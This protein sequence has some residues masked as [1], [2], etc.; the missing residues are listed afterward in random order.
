VTL[1]FAILI[2]VFAKT[3]AEISRCGNKCEVQVVE[4]GTGRVLSGIQLRIGEEVLKS[5]EN[6]FLMCTDQ[7]QDT[8]AVVLLNPAWRLRKTVLD[9][10]ANTERI[11]WL[12]RGATEA[13]G[14]YHKTGF[15]AQRLGKQSISE[16]PGSLQDPLRAVQNLAGV[17]RAPMNSG[18][19]L[20]RGMEPRDTRVFWA[21]LPLTQLMHLGGFASVFHPET[22]DSIRFQPT[23]W[24]DRV[25]GLGGQVEIQSA[26]KSD[27]RRAVLGADLI[28][29]SGY[30]TQPLGQ[31]WSGSASLRNSWLRGAMRLAQGEPAS[32]I[33]PRFRD[34]S[35]GVQGAKTSALYMGFEDEI[36][37]PTAD[38]EQ[39]LQIEQS[40][41]Q[42]LGQHTW[43][44]GSERLLLSGQL[45]TQ[46]QSLFQEGIRMRA[47][48]SQQARSHLEWSRNSAGLRIELGADVGLGNQAVR[49][50][51][52]QIQRQWAST[53]GFG[54]VEIGR[55]R[56]LGLGVRNTHL[57]VENQ[58]SRFGLDPAARFKWPV[59]R[60]QG[61]PVFLQGQLSRR[62]QAPDLALLV[63]DPEG[64][65]Q[66]LERA[67]ELSGGVL[68]DGR[69]SQENP[70]RLSVEGFSKVLRHLAMREADGTLGQFSGVA[71]GIEA[72]GQWQ[73]EDLTLGLSAGFSTSTR[74]EDSD[75]DV[76]P[77]ALDP[78]IQLVAVAIWKG[79]SDWTF[80]ARFRYASGVPFQ[81]DRPTAYD[82]FAQ[83]EVLLKPTV[84]EV[85]GR[86]PD[87]H[88]LDFKISKRRT[89]KRWRLQAYL[90]LQNLYNRRVPEPVL[91]GFE[92]QPVFGFGM[93]FL[94]VFGVEAWVWR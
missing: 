52:Q 80:S 89:Y 37:A 11:V 31:G 93:P 35:A 81:K 59:L 94:P 23:G 62:H 27:T 47:H 57:A 40:A 21:G 43:V 32:R 78:G 24:V 5:D 55:E 84:N 63:G 33:A 2:A 15:P 3:P 69:D 77:H 73:G 9:T 74:Q 8:L 58:G 48:E 72:A 90:D 87:P 64:H 19:L 66:P 44:W 49:F 6:G 12:E 60:L 7:G 39:I 42:I 38:G 76:T 54:S 1:F 67:D 36:D 79:P 30:I 16:L 50:V 46:V 71:R 10:T 85:T 14:T 18:W 82:L 25:G 45:A 75:H 88:A 86:L 20:V 83:Q 13:I 34:W 61:Q 70:L 92:E 56:L 29:T 68:F 28:N 22:V 51:P 26:P 17:A 4:R 65:A 91:T 41:H 53:E